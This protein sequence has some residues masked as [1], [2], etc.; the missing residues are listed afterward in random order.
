MSSADHSIERQLQA[1]DPEASTWVSASAGTGKTHVLT[2]RVLRLMLAGAPP[3]RILCLTFTKAAAAEMANRLN[4]RLGEWAVMEDEGLRRALFRLTGQPPETHDP[5]QARRLFCRVL[6][7]PGGMAIQTIHSFCQSLLARFPVEAQLAPRFDVVD[8]R[9][10]EELLAEARERVLAEDVAR[11]EPL[12][13][14][15]A[16]H[17]DE[18]RYMAVMRALAGAR[19]RLT[20]LARSGPTLDAVMR[21]TRARLALAPEDDAAGVLAAASGEAA[22]DGA[23]LYRVG[24]AMLE[25][26]KR[27]RENGRRITEWLENP[28]ARVAGID[29]YM[30]AFLTREGEPRASLIY[31]QALALEPDGEE[32]LAAEGARLQALDDKL[33]AI[34]VAEATAALLGLGFRVIEAYEAEKR[35]RGLVDFEDLILATRD[36]LA[37]PAAA[38]WVLFKLDGGI[39]HIL[40]DEAQDTNPEQWEVVRRLAEEFFAGESAREVRRTV[41]A[42][43][44]PKQSIYGFQR[45][46]PQGF[47]DMAGHFAARARNVG[48]TWHDLELVLSFRS[49]P[50]VL[51]LVDAVFQDASAG[52]G[53]IP[54]GGTARH[55]PHRRGQGGRVELWPPEVPLDEAPAEPWDP[56]VTQE[57]VERPLA[58]LAETLAERIRAWLDGGENLASEGRPIRAGDI[59][60]LV[61][62][63]GPFVTEVV[64]RLKQ[65]QVPVAGVDRM[66]LVEQLAVMD[67][68]ALGRFLLLPE[69]DLNLAA[70][71]KSPLVGL[72]EEAL[73]R[74]AR[75]RGPGR[76]LWRTLGA[77]R[78]HDP[79]LS[80]AHERLRRW[81]AAADF[82]AP[83]E[84]YSTVLDVEGGRRRLL[85]RLGR[86]ADEAI[87][88][89]LALTLAHEQQHTPSLQG[90]L[91]WIE[92]GR[93]EVKRD[94]ERARDEVRVMTVHGAKGQEAPIVILADTMRL[95]RSDPP[96]YWDHADDG[97]E[98]LFWVPRRRIEPAHCGALQRAAMR[99]R[100][101][102]YHRLLYVAMTRARDRLY[103]AGWQTRASLPEGCWYDLVQRAMAKLARPARLADGAEVL[104]HETPQLEAVAAAAAAPIGRDGETPAAWLERPAPPEPMPPRPLAP[105]DAGPEGP[106]VE[107]PLGGDRGARFRRGN[108]LHRLLQHLSEV[109]VPEREAVAERLLRQASVGDAA[110]RGELASEA[111][112]VLHTPEFAAL[113][114]PGSR[115]EVPIAGLVGARIVSGQIDRLAILDEEVLIVDYKSNRPAPGTAAEV[116]P[117]YLAQL[118]AYRAVLQGIYPSRRVR[119]ALLWTASP[120]L[121]EIPDDLLDRHA[122]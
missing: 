78:R 113:F 112:A 30:A 100:E 65:K 103:I 17:V 96:L 108:L 6:D 47:V 10:A 53:V 68:L 57:R 87:D 118:A 91:H 119:S 116:A 111:I 101:R 27:D 1:G 8:E 44:D 72:D 70:L 52:D 56:P 14:V 122:P 114:G 106:P 85:E 95:P 67:L 5:D 84:L 51:D 93:G 55:Y 82:T 71:L 97:S 18:E 88:E 41:F 77:R 80:A 40:I 37:D 28:A 120:R 24:E 102:E 42:V 74:A 22:F 36:L 7:A 75:D 13:A 29:D 62:R 99:E 43:G 121:M 105:S 49:T 59:M 39:D 48:E 60:I 23:N 89:F 94:M 25:G 73:Y 46:D 63:R 20:R 76:G 34:A 79:E 64:R 33:R 11:P 81:R 86:E 83:F 115:A 3:E 110:A 45:A 4:R 15:L 26:G 66:V 35:R 32:V 54:A 107:P 92:G 90:L 98:L 16:A 19:A 50:A 31:K 9:T 104:R 38:P 12:S 61:Q 2:S 21:R 69:D 109:P 58:R 117:V